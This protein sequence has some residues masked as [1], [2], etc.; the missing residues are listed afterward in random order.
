VRGSS[1]E[2][3][4]R[5]KLRWGTKA[6][7]RTISTTGDDNGSTRAGHDNRGCEEERAGRRGKSSVKGFYRQGDGGGKSVVGGKRFTVTLCWCRNSSAA[8]L[9][10][11]GMRSV[12][13][14]WRCRS[15]PLSRLERRRGRGADGV[16]WRGCALSNKTE[17][18]CTRG[19]RWRRYL[20]STC[21]RE[22]R[23]RREGPACHR[24]RRAWRGLE[25]GQIRVEWAGASCFIFS[26]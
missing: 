6:E 7:A 25:M 4:Q 5:A 24:N 20:D 14:S 18:S 19:R 11:K 26:F 16:S 9:G 22:K 12:A 23:E 10:K 2:H 8:R 15:T 1:A 13:S 21:H 3:R 17:E